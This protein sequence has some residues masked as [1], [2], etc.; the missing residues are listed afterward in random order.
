MRVK[1]F[2]G[3]SPATLILR[4]SSDICNSFLSDRP[5]RTEFLIVCYGEIN[6]EYAVRLILILCALWS[7]WCLR[8]I[9]AEAQTN[10]QVFVL[11]G[12][13]FEKGRALFFGEQLKCSTCHLIRG[14]GV[15]SDLSKLM[16]RGANS[17]LDDIKGRGISSTPH[18]AKD[19]FGALK[20][21]QE[22]DLLTFLLNEPPKRTKAEVN[23]ILKSSRTRL[24][25]SRYD[26][27]LNIVLVASKQDHGSGQHDYPAWQKKWH[28]LLAKAVNVT[29]TDAWQWPSE[30]QFKKA[31]VLVF[32]FWN[33]DWSTE[34]LKQVDDYQARG[35]GIVLLHSAIIADKDAEELAERMGLASQPVRSKYLHTPLDFKVTA[36]ADNPVTRGI[37]QIHFLDEPYWSLIGDASKVQVLGTVDEEGSACPVMWTFMRG[38][39]RVFGSV[40][41]HY[42][43]TGDDP[44]FRILILRGIGWAA[45]EDERRF[46]RLATKD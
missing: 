37:K 13:D 32:Y 42:T 33:H 17:V 41:G 30:E 8:V 25:K 23:A 46:E 40:L 36:S 45:G 38:K 1:Q 28:P 15:G 10:I 22:R 20:E 18:H 9:C 3:V 5:R 35:G 19:L 14:E 6:E 11:S 2:A 39:G 27:M 21:E 43:W 24:Q 34:R 29:V 16:S 44:L 26:H 4:G 31:D 12:G 7:G